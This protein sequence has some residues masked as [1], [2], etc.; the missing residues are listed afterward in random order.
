MLLVD[1]LAQ[2]N[3]REE[4]VQVI[5]RALTRPPSS[6]RLQVML[7]TLLEQTGQVAEARMR[8]EAIIAA[9]RKAGGVAARLAALYANQRENLDRALEFA[10]MAKKQLPNDP[11]VSDTLGWVYVRMG[12]PSLGA[13]HLKD[14][15]RAQPATALFRYHLGIAHQQQMEI[16]AARAELTRALALDPD[17]PGATDARAALDTLAKLPVSGAK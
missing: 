6:F 5:K 2:Q 14:A 1:V 9:N 13:P 10:N 12:V 4:A 17:F 16:G 15:V 3:R 8:Y 7:A 11:S